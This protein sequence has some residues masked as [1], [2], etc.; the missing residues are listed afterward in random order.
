MGKKIAKPLF[1]IVLVFVVGSLIFLL[2]PISAQEESSMAIRRFIDREASTGFYG[3]HEARPQRQKLMV[4]IPGLRRGV[5]SYS[6]SG[7]KVR[8]R[9]RLR[10]SHQGL[11]FYKARTCISCHPSE[12]KD[13]H[14]VQGNLTCRQ[15]HGFEPISGLDHYYSPFNPVRRHAYVCSKCHEGATASYASYIVHEP[16]AHS[17]EA[18]L[19]FPILYWVHWA[20]FLLLVGTLA[21]FIPHSLLLGIRG[22]IKSGKKHK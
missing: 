8:S 21:A 11:R 6:P 5:F 9:S 7:A 19:E 10:D 12:A 1:I 2:A 4:S 18:R 13:V 20:M 16:L 17:K 15:C 3:T 14:T 22:L